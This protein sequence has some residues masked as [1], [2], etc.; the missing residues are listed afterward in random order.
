MAGRRAPPAIEDAVTTANPSPRPAAAGWHPTLTRAVDRIGAPT[1]ALVGLVVAGLVVL[2]AYRWHLTPDGV[3]YLSI[4]RHLAEGRFLDAVNPYWSPLLSWLLAPLLAVGIPPL[5]AFKL[6]GIL[7]AVAALL[8][9]DRLLV[10]T[11]ADRVAR[12]VTL[13]GAVPLL[14]HAAVTWMSPDLLVAVPVL[15]LTDRVVRRRWQ[16]STPAAFGTGALA[17]VAYLAKLYALPVVAVVLAVAALLA[18]RRE[19][20]RTARRVVALAA[21]LATVLATW[22]G[23]LSLVVGA[24]TLG[25]AGSVNVEVLGRGTQGQPVLTQGLFV[26]PTP[27]A[28]SAWED[29]SQLIPSPSSDEERAPLERPASQGDGA[30][31]PDVPGAGRWY[32]LVDNVAENLRRTAEVAGTWWL[33]VGVVLVGAV[34]GLVRRRHTVGG[35]ADARLLAVVGVAAVWAGG[36]L[37][38]VVHARYLWVSML[39]LLPVIAAGLTRARGR[40]VLPV[41]AAAALVAWVGPSVAELD[42]QR[43][44]GPGIAALAQELRAAGI[45]PG[46]RLSSDRHWGIGATVCFH[47]DCRYHGVPR[48]PTDGPALAAELAEHDIDWHLGWD[49]VEAP[50][51]ASAASRAAVETGEGAVLYRLDHAR[52]R[53]DG[54]G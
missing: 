11:G 21:G 37:P 24:P 4:A 6:V 30:S 35:P 22:G 26:P 17:G 9:V 51:P 5:V 8:A 16:R 40:A 13:L 19:G 12:A 33:A 44:F 42:R 29:P 10:T 38:L 2:P 45:A 25:T 53:A 34:A 47:L 46:D 28:I 54:T 15:W 3:A 20:R 7:A 39:L 18:L 31:S 36:L 52:A 23:I 32:G 41:L 14:V 50:S 49:S 48:Q 1:A 27:F 43:Q